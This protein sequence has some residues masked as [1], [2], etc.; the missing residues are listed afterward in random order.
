MAGRP[1]KYKA[2]YAKQAEKLCDLGAT[3]VDL[4]EFFDVEVRTIYRWKITHK[5]FCQ[6]LTASKEGYDSRVERAVALRAIGYSHPDV[7][8]RVIEGEIVKTEIIKHY[9]PDTKAALAWLYNRKSD[10]WHP[11]PTDSGNEDETLAK[12]LLLLADKLPG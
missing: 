7:D 11:N 9:P 5:A 3:D 12:A 2:E 1:T 8:I 4:A 6:A 10:K